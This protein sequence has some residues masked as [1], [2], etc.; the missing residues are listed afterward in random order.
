MPLIVVR[1]TA[2]ATTVEAFVARFARYFRDGEVVFVP[3]EGVQPSGRRVKFVFALAGG[4]E[5]VHGEGVV[6]RMRRDSGDP[7]RPPGME[8]RYE[9]SDE[10]SAK[11]IE[12]LLAAR[13]TPPPYVSM[14]IDGVADSQEL[15]VPIERVEPPPAPATPPTT[16]HAPTTPPPIP[17]PPATPIPSTRISSRPLP[18]I[19]SAP[20]PAHV[21]IDPPRLWPSSPPPSSS[22]RAARLL[23]TAIA[24]SA[25]VLAVTLAAAIMRRAPPPPPPHAHAVGGNGAVVV[26]TS[27]PPRIAPSASPPVVA[28]PVVAGPR[29][30]S[31][32]AARPPS[33]PARARV[34]APSLQ[35][36]VTTSPPG[37]LVFVDGEERGESPLSISV[38]AG[39]HD[40]VAERP[41]WVS[42]H[43][44]VDGPGRVQLTLARP[45]ARLHIVSTVPGAAVKLDGRDVGTTPLEL[46]ADAYELHV[47]RVELDGHVWRRKLYLRPPGGNVHVGARNPTS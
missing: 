7:R 22:S 33:A 20:P 15:T 23:G 39:A 18:P 2:E 13:K 36:R 37:A 10:P 44:R 43:A 27:T 35:L 17:R 47:I 38:V 3:T 31:T 21:P 8:L 45:Q 32:G 26:A 34:A 28:A 14:R 46:D 12:R 5:V 19:A 30:V 16:M 24:T 9:I 40:V 41:R 42:A 6:L 4:E 1:V 29:P 25:A 11:M